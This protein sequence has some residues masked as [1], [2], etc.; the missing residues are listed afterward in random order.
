[1]RI[2]LI[3]AL[4]AVLF[5]SVSL[6]ADWDTFQN[7]AAHDG[8]VQVTTNAS[9]SSIAWQIQLPAT[10]LTGLAIGDGNV[11]VSNG[12]I[13]Q[14]QNGAISFFAL[15]QQ[16]GNVAWTKA[17]SSTTPSWPLVFSINAPAYSNGTVYLQTSNNSFGTNLYA[18]NAATG[19]SDY[20]APF[21]SQWETYLAPT[22]F[23]GNIYMDGGYY[24]G[25]YSFSGSS[26]NQN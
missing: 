11:F 14:V 8:Y 13:Q 23:G 9:Q 2:Q 20:V 15:N 21:A 10:N 3:C 16:T 24:G 1:M 4:L 7:D 19:T 5:S 6:K 25:M 12:S 17:F 26:G 18:F 22:P